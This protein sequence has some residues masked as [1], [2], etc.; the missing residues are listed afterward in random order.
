MSINT[1]DYNGF[2]SV[3]ININDTNVINYLPSGH[4]QLNSGVIVN[5]IIDNINNADNE[6]LITS[7]TMKD[8]VDLVSGTTDTVITLNNT[9]TTISTISTTN[10]TFYSVR[11]IISGRNQ[12]NGTDFAMYRYLF[13]VK[14]ISGVVSITKNKLLET[15]EEDDAAWNIQ[16]NVSGTNVQIQVVG[17]PS[18]SIIWKSTV[19]IQDL[20]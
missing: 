5:N 11:A 16:L 12:T 9:A 19:Y 7:I 4:I 3:N 1:I 18:D 20:S 15:I 14:N 17:D 2:V 6:S 8:Y 13:G 10:N